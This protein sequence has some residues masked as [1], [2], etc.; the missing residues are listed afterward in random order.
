MT[1]IAVCDNI[2]AADTQG[3]FED[4]IMEMHKIF[5]VR[6]ELIGTCGNYDNAVKFIELYK[7]GQKYVTQ[8]SNGTDEND[9]DYLLLNAKGLYL[10]TGFRGPKVKVHERFWSI[11]S[12]KEAAITAMRM[13]A[14]PKEAVKMASLCDVYTGSK[15]QVREL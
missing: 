2:M 3:R 4:I 9:F 7:K 11:G 13:G 12:G 6:D 15:V 8:S 1:T 14:T 5:R 10:A